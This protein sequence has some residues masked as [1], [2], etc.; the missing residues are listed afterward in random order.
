MEAEGGRKITTE[1][2][3][4]VDLAVPNSLEEALEKHKFM[5]IH[6]LPRP[7]IN[8]GIRSVL[9]APVMYQKDCFGIFYIENSTEHSHYSLMDLDYLVL[10]ALY[11]GILIQRLRET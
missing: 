10:L 11:T 7:I 8:R 4:R 3:Q 9:I 1:A 2:V 6:Q 5:L